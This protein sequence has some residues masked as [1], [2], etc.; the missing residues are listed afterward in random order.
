M[1]CGHQVR[2]DF[3]PTCSVTWKCWKRITP[4][5]HVIFP[6]HHT[7]TVHVLICFTVISLRPNEI[8]VCVC[9]HLLINPHQ[10]KIRL[11][12]RL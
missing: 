3:Y 1:L 5:G 10:I 7:P 8:C 6:K 2:L 12:N 11:A 4:H 9:D